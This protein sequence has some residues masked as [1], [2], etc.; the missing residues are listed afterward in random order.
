MIKPDSVRRHLTAALASAYPEILTDPERLLVSVDKGR[1]AATGARLAGGATG[2]RYDY[3]LV[4]TLIDFPAA[5]GP[6]AVFLP[7]VSWLARHQPQVLQSY[8]TNPEALR[9]ELDVVAADKVDLQVTVA[10]SESV[11]AVRDDDGV[12]AFTTHAEPD[13]DEHVAR[14]GETFRIVFNGVTVAEWTELPAP[15]DAE[16]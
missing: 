15:P 4:L 8:T 12:F 14:A 5:I 2:A 6:N 10:L 7:L 9:F 13:A 3:D 1:V 16:L 11:T